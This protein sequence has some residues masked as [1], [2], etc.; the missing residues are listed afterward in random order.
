LTQVNLASR[1]RLQEVYA[2]EQRLLARIATTSVRRHGRKLR[3]DVKKDTAQALGTRAGNTWSRPLF[4]PPKGFSMAPAAYIF[5]KMPAA[6]IGHDA[7][8]MLIRPVKGGWLA[9]P[10]EHAPTRGKGRF[11][12]L[13]LTP[14]SYAKV[15]GVR[16]RFVALS[17][18]RAMLVDDNLP[19]GPQPV[20]WLVRGVTLHR[21]VHATQLAGKALR[22]LVN[23]VAYL[24][25]TAEVERA[26][27]LAD[28]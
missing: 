7:E 17:G 12:K 21:R 19:G 13:S 23:E 2:V 16:L 18:N 9:I 10:T 22:T 8:S 20:F 11:H 28:A 24:Y 5:S 26:D 4:Y 6:I 14:Q 15:F 3:N 1:G 25:N 27:Q